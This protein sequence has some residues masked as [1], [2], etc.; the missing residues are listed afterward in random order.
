ML[1]GIIADDFTGASDIAVTLSKGIADEGGL[2]T[3]LF[4]GTPARDAPAGV[5][6]GVIALK[7]RSIPA[8]QAVTQS[9]KACG[10]LLSQGCSQIVFKYC[11]T[12]DSTSEGNIGPV[13]DAL[14]KFL[15]ARA[16]PVCPS[17]PA[18][19]RTVYQ[20]HLFVHDK[21]LN[22]SGMEHHPLTPMRDANLCRVLKQQSSSK[23]GHISW[24]KVSEGA[25]AI[26]KSLDSAAASGEILTVIDAISENDL[27]SIG[28]ACAESRLITGGSAVAIGLPHNF[29]SKGLAAGA[30]SRVP[31]IDG[32]EAILVGSCSRTTLRQ[33]SEHA[34]S[35]PVMMIA[36][37]DVMSGKVS[38]DKLVEFILSNQGKSPL[39]FTSDDKAEV[40]MSQS[41]YGREKVSAALE[42]LFGETARKL[43]EGGVRRLVVG[44]GETSGAVV[45]ALNLD[46]LMIG[47]EIDTG[48]PALVSLGEHPLSLA[49]KSGNFGATDFFA[50]AVRTL[51]GKE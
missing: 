6:A 39:I 18:M 17:F 22:E 33:I 43:I 1:I 32:P 19:G 20:G 44:G 46:A 10:W 42:G 49:L 4:L 45:S 15:D 27:I 3:T 35:Y 11:S 50:K 28:E 24:Q 26:R 5:E 41:I 51:R 37:D 25:A 29:I 40:A 12:F 38:S 7:S 8:E 31:C 21:L 36:V 23:I 47:D 9:L 30:H 13:A 16:V 2:R 48:I 14:A 34:K